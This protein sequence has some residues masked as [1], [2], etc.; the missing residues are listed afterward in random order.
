MAEQILATA[1]EAS[2]DTDPMDALQDFGW[3]ATYERDDGSLKAV[4]L[5]EVPL[6]YACG[7]A[8][9]GMS[10]L[11]MSSEAEKAQMEAE[12]ADAFREFVNIKASIFNVTDE[13]HV[14][15]RAVHEGPGWPDEL[16][17]F[18]R[19]AKVSLHMHMSVPDLGGGR[20]LWLAQ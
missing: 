19:G 17:S 1:V 5:Y 18:M 12:L 13:E 4:C 3:L 7:M 15:L 11:D 2:S 8:L 6:A 20:M 9:L 14:K 10:G 16:M